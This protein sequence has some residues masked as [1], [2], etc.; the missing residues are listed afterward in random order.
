[1][2][3]DY[4]VMVSKDCYFDAYMFDGLKKEYIQGVPERMPQAC[5][6]KSQEI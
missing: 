5:K 1:M 3:A 6:I 2:Y 4:V